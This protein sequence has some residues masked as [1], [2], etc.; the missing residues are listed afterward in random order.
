MRGNFQQFRPGDGGGRGTS[1][2]SSPPSCPSPHPAAAR[3]H[4]TC[5][6]NDVAIA[7]RRNI[8]PCRHIV[9]TH[10]C[11]RNRYAARRDVVWCATAGTEKK[12]AAVTWSWRTPPPPPPSPWTPLGPKTDRSTRLRHALRSDEARRGGGAA[13]RGE[14]TR[15]STKNRTEQTEAHARTYVRANLRALRDAAQ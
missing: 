3:T 12:Y 7:W 8:A 5:S 4:V 13:W 6:K 15:C 2:S 11:A 10:R 9:L 1:F 14:I